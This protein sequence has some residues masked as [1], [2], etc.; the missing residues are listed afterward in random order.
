MQNDIANEIRRSVWLAALFYGGPVYPISY[1]DWSEF[2]SSKKS[3]KNIFDYKMSSFE[4]SYSRDTW[5]QYYGGRANYSRELVKRFLDDI[6]NEVEIDWNNTSNPKD[7]T[8]SEFNGTFN[9]S[10]EIPLVLGYLHMKNG[11]VY[12]WVA[13]LNINLS[14]IYKVL[15]FIKK[16]ENKTDTEVLEMVKSKF[17][18]AL[19]GADYMFCPTI[20]NEED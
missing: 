14:G 2:K 9:D 5:W 20:K 4:E 17:E 16:W 11:N 3:S 12:P 1:H 18:K 15:E 7:Y 8:E 10:T 6:E 13:N 19:K